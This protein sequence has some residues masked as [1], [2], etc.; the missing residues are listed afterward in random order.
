MDEKGAEV[1]YPAHKGELYP[2]CGEVFIRPMGAWGIDA[3]EAL[4]EKYLQ[5]IQA[6]VEP[7]D[8]KIIYHAS[9][10]ILMRQEA[11]LRGDIYQWIRVGTY[12]DEDRIYYT[13][14]DASTGAMFNSWRFR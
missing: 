12:I 2:F 9:Q 13:D 3:V 8:L 4:R 14:M 5:Q 1:M 7:E 6:G 10:E 11:A